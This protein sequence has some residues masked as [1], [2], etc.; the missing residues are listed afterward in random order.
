LDDKFGTILSCFVHLIDTFKY[1]AK[2]PT[3]RDE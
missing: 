2:F 3:H 1:F